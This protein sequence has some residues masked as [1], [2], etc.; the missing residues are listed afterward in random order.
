MK[1]AGFDLSSLKTGIR[2]NIN[3]NVLNSTH[4]DNRQIH[5]T[6]GKKTN[7]KKILE[8]VNSNKLL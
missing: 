4:N 6:T 5:I 8:E 7:L 2:L 3:F 1:I